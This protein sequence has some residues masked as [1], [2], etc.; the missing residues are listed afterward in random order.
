MS[1]PMRQNNRFG[2]KGEAS[3]IGLLHNA[4]VREPLQPGAFSVRGVDQAASWLK[5]LPKLNAVA[6]AQ[7]GRLPGLAWCTT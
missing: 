1:F 3:L 4:V 6:C 5:T 7:E 2:P